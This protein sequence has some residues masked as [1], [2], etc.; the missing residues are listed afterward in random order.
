MKLTDACDVVHEYD[1]R[2]DDAFLVQDAEL[3]SRWVVIPV[4][5]MYD[6]YNQIAK[7][8]RAQQALAALKKQ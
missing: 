8:L 4:W 3:T 6:S 7:S 2:E 5:L 1:V